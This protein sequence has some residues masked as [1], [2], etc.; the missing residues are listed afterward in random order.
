MILK[1]E[2]KINKVNWKFL[3]IEYLERSKKDL[4]NKNKIV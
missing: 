4:E 2:S 3:M 1:E